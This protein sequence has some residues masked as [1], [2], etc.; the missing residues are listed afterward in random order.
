MQGG[1]LLRT[2]DFAVIEADKEADNTTHNEDE[3]DEVE[4]CNVLP[5]GL[6]LLVGIQLEED[7]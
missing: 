2:A 4:L 1:N 6:A 7:E 3:P 5:F